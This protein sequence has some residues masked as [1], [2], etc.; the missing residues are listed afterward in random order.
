MPAIHPQPGMPVSSYLYLNELRVHYR[1]WNLGDDGQPIV[2]LHGLASN[3]RIWDLVAPYLVKSKMV[4]LALDARG[5]GLTD[6]LSQGYDI[7]AMIADLAAFVDSLHLE[8]PLLVGHSWGANL[9]LEYATRFPFGLLA[10]SGIVLIDGGMV[11]LDDSPGASWE[12]TEKRLTPPK[13][14]GFALEDF[15]NRLHGWTADWL[16]EGE[17]GEQILNIILGNFEIDDEERI[18]PHLSFENHM[19]IV[20]AMWEF[21]TYERYPRLHCPVLMLPVRPK[22]PL[23][24]RDRTFLEA[25]ERGVGRALENISKLQVHWMADS[26]HDVPLQRPTEVAENILAFARSI[27]IL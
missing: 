14:A 25:K 17:P 12:E 26:I 15:I 1:H 20:R 13:L 10:P 24:D 19:Q 11:Q 7:D 2:L 9:A 8:G 18:F 5:H 6:K 21:K 3:A 23:S 4:P 27:A 16:P 22:E